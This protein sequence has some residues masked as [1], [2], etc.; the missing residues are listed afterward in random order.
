MPRD[1]IRVVI[2]YDPRE[3]AAYRVCK[4][5]LLTRASVP[6]H[7]VRLDIDWL[8]RT[9][10]YRRQEFAIDG[11]RYDM[12]DEKPF[13]T[14]FSFS[15]FLT[16]SLFPDGWAVFCDSDMLWRGDVAELWNLRDNRYAAMVV[17]HDYQPEEGA[18]MRGQRQERYARKNWSSVVLWNCEHPANR[19]HL[20]PYVVSK[21]PGAWLHGFSW[22]KDDEIG[23][24]PAWW[25]WLEGHSSE[26]ICPHIVH[27]TRGT[28]DMPG[29]ESTKYADEWR[30]FLEVA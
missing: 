3:D 23:S 7:V 24:L 2:G 20:T 10:L 15:R 5:S 30:S 17:K 28:P 1:P 13:S 4:H 12:Q 26:D 11:Q 16:P 29:L 21:A 6:V 8:R 9:A 22:L 19:L 27:Y 25:N 18:K 14:D